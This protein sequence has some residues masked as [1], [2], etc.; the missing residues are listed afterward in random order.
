MFCGKTSN[1]EIN[2]IHKRSLHIL[3]NDYEAS[4][5]ELLQRNDEQTVHTKNLHNLMTE[6]YKSL[7]LQ[8]PAFMLDLF[9]RKEVTYDLRVKDLL[10]LP[11]VKATLP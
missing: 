4:F 9:I 5:E 1:R 8:N 7:N 3:F 6:V 11:I 10:Q 2:R